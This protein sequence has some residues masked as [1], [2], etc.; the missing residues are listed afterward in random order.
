MKT[1]IKC[2][3]SLT[4]L[5][6]LQNAFAADSTNDHNSEKSTHTDW[7]KVFPQPTPNLSKSTL[8]ASTQLLSPE[9]HA[10]VKAGDVTLKWK[11]VP[12]VMYHL[13]VATDPNFKWLV[14]EEKLVTFTEYTLK[15][16]KPNQQYFWRVYT[17]IP[18]N[19]P[20]YTKGAA[21]KS[22]FETTE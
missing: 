14:A 6:S 15:G 7:N 4:I 17:Q 10:K 8:P 5:L 13:Q 2:L 9:F 1:L 3:I 18:D 22:S 20:S 11:A 16:A 12:S 21:V 19:T